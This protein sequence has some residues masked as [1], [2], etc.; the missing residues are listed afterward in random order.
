MKN[1]LVI[2]GAGY[3]GSHIVYDLNDRGHNVI[4]YDNLSSGFEKNVDKR[5]DLIVGDFFD[6]KL[7]SKSLKNIDVVIHLAALKDA[8][9]SMMNLSKYANHNIIGSLKLIESCI[10]NN[11]NSFIFSSTAAVYGLPKYLPVDE[12]HSLEPIN[13]YGY[14][15][16]C[17]ERNLLWYNKIKKIKIACLRYFNAAGYDIKGR[18]RIKEKN[19][20][21]LLP[22]VMEV[23]CGQRKKMQI[24]GNDYNTLDGTCLRDYIHVN[25]LASAHSLSLE[26]L[27][28][29]NKPLILN[30]ST[31]KSFSVYDVIKTAEI[32]SNKKINFEV[33]D[34]RAGDPGKLYSNSLRA[35]DLLNWKPK[36][37]DLSTIIQSMWDIYK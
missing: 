35:N 17:I 25:D 34:R 16:L 32:V 37:S 36:F 30:L 8:G 7:L 28:V 27:D 10:K 4:V 15:K 20:S 26:Y 3:I 23:L 6:E 5:A 29:N 12:N 24:Y 1:I 2:G 18:I 21:N 11:I 19:V 13:Y 14:T 9:E 22:I 31:G 33:I